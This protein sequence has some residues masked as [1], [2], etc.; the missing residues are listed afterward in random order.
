MGIGGNLYEIE[1]RLVGELPRFLDID[2]SAINSFSV[3]KLNLRDSNLVVDAGPFLD[4]RGGTIGTA[5]GQ[6]SFNCC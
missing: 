3:D 1:A 4:G 6:F 5:N 2:Y